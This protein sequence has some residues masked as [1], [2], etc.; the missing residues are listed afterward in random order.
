MYSSH[1]ER[2]KKSRRL[3]EDGGDEGRDGEGAEHGEGAEEGQVGKGGTP[4]PKRS[5]EGVNERSQLVDNAHL[6]LNPC[7]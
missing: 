6:S 2:G 5:Q 7:E 4:K 3:S 1:R